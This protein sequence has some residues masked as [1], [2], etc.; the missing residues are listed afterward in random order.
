MGIN[1]THYNTN[2][3][4]YLIEPYGVTTKRVQ[5]NFDGNTVIIIP[6][7]I[8]LEELSKCLFSTRNK[9]P[10]YLL[11][12][13]FESDT[14]I[15][16][17]TKLPSWEI[18][19]FYN[20]LYRAKIS[21]KNAAVLINNLRYDGLTTHYY[22]DKIIQTIS[23]PRWLY[24]YNLGLG[25]PHLDRKKLAK[26]Q[27]SCFNLRGTE[28]KQLAV[29]YINLIKLPTYIT[30]IYNRNFSVAGLQNPDDAATNKNSIELPKE[31]YYIG[32]VNICTESRYFKSKGFSDVI[33]ITEKTF[34]NIAYGIP[35][36][37]IGQQYTLQV[38]KKLGFKTFDSLINEEYDI[39]NDDIRYIHAIQA[40]IDLRNFYHSKRLQAILDYNRELIRDKSF[41]QKY[42][43][44]TFIKSIN[45][46]IE[47]KDKMILL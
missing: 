16:S 7:D 9:K 29:E 11:D 12:Y 45:T 41:G 26:E 10:I 19:A 31:I 47:K 5:P 34:R 18:I 21:Y 30:Y 40:G 20:E 27:Y 46:L 24:E 1:F 28:H 2:H 38:L 42:F 4:D 8:E 6:H 39:M 15:D 37:V 32:R 3:S 17:N 33:C 25:L 35:F 22:K 14:Y 43:N 13:T 36:V 44:E 23:F